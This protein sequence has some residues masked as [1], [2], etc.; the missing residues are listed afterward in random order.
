MEKLFYFLFGIFLSFLGSS[1]YYHES[2]DATDA[3]IAKMKGKTVITI[4]YSD[5]MTEAYD[6][7]SSSGHRTSVLI[8]SEEDYGKIVKEVLEHVSRTVDEIA[9]GTWKKKLKGR[10]K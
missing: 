10:M 2:G 6:I 4:G 7:T 1:C 3:D 9:R 5:G 8:P